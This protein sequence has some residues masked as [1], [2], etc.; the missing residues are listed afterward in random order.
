MCGIWNAV[1]ENGSQSTAR[2]QDVRFAGCKGEDRGQRVGKGRML[3]EVHTGERQHDIH[4]QYQEIVLGGRGW[5]LVHQLNFFSAL[6]QINRKSGFQ[7]H[8]RHIVLKEGSCGEAP[9]NLPVVNA[10]KSLN[11][12][13]HQIW[14]LTLQIIEY[15]PAAG[16]YSC[17][18]LKIY[19]FMICF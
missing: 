14:V 18:I 2:K 4:V 16:A 15:Y 10:T 12:H 11:P 6:Y 13:I 5:L 17:Q 9:I 1:L 19:Q 3:A 7:S 8:S